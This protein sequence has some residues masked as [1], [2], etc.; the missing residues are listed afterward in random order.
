MTLTDQQIETTLAA[1]RHERAGYVARG[2][3]ARAAAVDEQIALLSGEPA[4]QP[5]ART[6]LRR[7]AGAETRASRA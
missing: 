5:H 1:L 6:R 4:D 7:S 2:L 3:D